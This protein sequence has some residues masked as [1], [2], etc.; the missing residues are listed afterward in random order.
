MLIAEDNQLLALM[1][2]KILNDLN[3]ENTIVH[4]RKNML[5]ANHND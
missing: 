2:D 4:S 3:L 1:I 5:L